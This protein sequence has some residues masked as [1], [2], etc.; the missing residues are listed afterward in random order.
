MRKPLLTALFVAS[1]GC[2]SVPALARTNVDFFVNVGPPAVQYEYVP[3]PR[4]GYTWVPGYWDWRG[5]NQVWVEGSWFRDRPAYYYDAPQRVEWA[6][7]LYS[8]RSRWHH[9]NHYLHDHDGDG[10]PDRY[11]RYPHDPY[12]H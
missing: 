11:D 8:D 4:Y 9:R 2:V 7:G 3:A 6:N 12:R 10:V 5:R 1:I